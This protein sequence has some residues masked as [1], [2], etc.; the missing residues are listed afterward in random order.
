MRFFVAC[1]SLTK[2]ARLTKREIIFL[3]IICVLVLVILIGV[4]PIMIGTAIN[5]NHPPRNNAIANQTDSAAP[6]AGTDA[7]KQP[8][9]ADLLIMV[10]GKISIME[11]AG[12]SFVVLTSDY[13]KKYIL[14]G[15]KAEEI[16]EFAGKD[17]V[18]TVVGKPKA[19]LVKELKGE[20]IKRNIEVKNF[21]I[22]KE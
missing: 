18:L 3:S 19:P 22:K 17:A 20:E 2:E 8:K 11:E 13:A 16:K 6:A 5:K 1:F 14:T 12:V 4:I 9:K 7:P 15:P 10:S 21:Q